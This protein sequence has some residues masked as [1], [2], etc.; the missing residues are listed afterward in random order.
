MK[1][2]YPTHPIR[3]FNDW[4]SSVHNYFRMN[5]A[6]YVRNKNVRTYTPFII[7]NGK[8][9][10]LVDGKEI[11]QKEFEAQF[12]LPLVLKKV[13]GNPDKTKDFMNDLY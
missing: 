1:T 3:D 6:E 8:G 4:I 10:Y 2:I 9:F 7:K 12:P 5:V 13:E 11:P